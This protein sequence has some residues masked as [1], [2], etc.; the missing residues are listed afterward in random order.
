MPFT[1][2]GVETGSWRLTFFT[3]IPPALIP[4]VD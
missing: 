4:V 2:K 3:P 1:E